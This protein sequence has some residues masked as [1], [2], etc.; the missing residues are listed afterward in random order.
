MAFLRH[1]VSGGASLLPLGTT[2]EDH[3]QRLKGQLR[4]V[5]TREGGIALIEAGGA[6]SE[7]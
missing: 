5:Q 7:A 1:E 2:A 3:L 4:P 6:R